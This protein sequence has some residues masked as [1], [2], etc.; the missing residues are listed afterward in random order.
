MWMRITTCLLNKWWKRFA[1]KKKNLLTARVVGPTCEVRFCL[2]GPPDRNSLL[3]VIC[4]NPTPEPM[5]IHPCTWLFSLLHEYWY[6]SSTYTTTTQSK[7]HI[8]NRDL[9]CI[10][11]RDG[12]YSSSYPSLPVRVFP[13]LK[14]W[15][16][17]NVYNLFHLHILLLSPKTIAFFSLLEHLLLPFPF[18]FHLYLIRDGNIPPIC[19]P[20]PR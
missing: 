19:Q 13:I 8:F 7:L 10:Q 16:A 4:Q 3:G 15:W 18:L 11:C 1:K 12:K 17:S 2:R 9:A 20:T 5:E 14:W 6:L